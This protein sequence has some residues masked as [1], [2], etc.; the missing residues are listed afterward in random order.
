MRTI[1]ADE[2][3]ANLHK[4]FPQASLEGIEAKTLFAQI[5]ADIDNT[6]TVYP[7]CEDKAC[8]YRANERPQGEWLHPYSVNIACECSICHLQLP[9]LDCFHFCPNCG[10]EMRKGGA[11]NA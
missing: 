3:K 5:L 7:I 10:A 8:K 2:L 6:P 1:N 4:W 11:E 9:I